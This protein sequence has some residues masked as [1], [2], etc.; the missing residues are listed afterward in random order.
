M[1]HDPSAATPIASVTDR[2]RAA[3][4]QMTLWCIVAAAPFVVIPLMLG[5][6]ERPDRA[7]H[8]FPVAPLLWV[9]VL[10][11]A[12]RM[13][14]GGNQRSSAVTLCVAV[15]TVLIYGLFNLG[16]FMGNGAGWVITL[17]FSEFLL[18]R[19]VG[20]W[21][22]LTFAATAATHTALLA[23]GVMTLSF[24]SPQETDL[25][26]LVRIYGATLIGLG[27]G[28]FIVRR[29]ID[30]I[31]ESHAEQ[32]REHALRE[33]ASA[34]R[35]E[36]EKRMQANQHF[37]ALGKLAGGIAHDVNNALSTVLCAIE[38]LRASS[39]QP[40][41]VDLLSDIESATRSAAQTA[42]HLLSL[43]RRADNLP[44]SV[45]PNQGVGAVC[46]LASRV[47]PEGITITP[48]NRSTE[49]ILADPID[50]QQALLNLLLNARDAI[51]G[52]GEIIV[53][54]RDETD[55]ARADARRV[56]IEVQDSG[57]G[58]SP[59]TAALL[60]QPFFTTKAPGQGTG[61]GLTM[62][63]QFVDA[64]G[65]SVSWHSEPAAGTTF[66][67]TF[68]ASTSA[69]SAALP[70]ADWSMSAHVKPA[71]VLLV[72]DQDELRQVIRRT[73]ERE[74]HV[75]TSEATI[76]SALAHLARG[77]TY[78]LLCTDGLV[79]ATPTIRL[80]ERFRASQAESRP[81]LMIS[82]Q[83]DEVLAAA[84]IP[85]SC[86]DTFLRKPFSGSELIAAVR[87]LLPAT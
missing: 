20:R 35:Y 11:V 13:K 59:E 12:W 66:S 76:E 72:E 50:L 41:E 68:P 1:T 53:R 27:G 37:E 81:V 73:L 5:W 33:E 60:F 45:D 87:H 52:R 24:H 51:P 62:V 58:I 29:S 54:T 25:L 3:A 44:E 17:I 19:Q 28:R 56:V 18:G 69:A 80:I 49:R 77:E 74:G 55:P 84:D 10:L 26:A 85:R 21:I 39:Q 38:L 6:G 16:P 36:A 8:N 2:A 70:P 42:R 61:L 31:E 86:A 30:L 23:T 48:V 15:V 43:N 78:D 79:S 7:W 63:K 9:G 71:A 14:R 67:L 40:A 22:I 65:G 75:V 82:G 4:F 34:A 83:A 47:M 64:T 32:V 46:R 57:S